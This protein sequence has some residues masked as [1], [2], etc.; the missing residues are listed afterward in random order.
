MRRR[1]AALRA[2]A[3]LCLAAVGLLW[4]PAPEVSAQS[5][6]AEVGWWYRLSGDNP[7]PSGAGAGGAAP[8]QAAPPPTLPP[9]PAPV[10]TI[11]V[12]EDDPPALPAPVPPPATVP[13]GGLYVANDAFGALAIAAVRFPVGQVGS[14]ILTL[15]FADG[16]GGAALPIVA[17]P[18]LEGFQAVAN[19]AWR[20]RP[21]H[22]CD[23]ASVSGALGSDGTLTFQL[24]ERFQQAGQQTLDVVVL[25]LPGDG[26]PFSAPFQA[27]GADALEVLGP[28]PDR[29][30]ASPS[31][32]GT[33]AGPR[34]GST[35]SAVPAQGGSGARSPAV[36]RVP[37]APATPSAGAGGGEAAGGVTPVVQPVAELFDDR[38]WARW[39]AT[40]ILGVLAVAVA[41]ASTGKVPPLAGAGG[42][43]ATKGVGRFA[44][45]REGPPP[46]LT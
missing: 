36:G 17:C 30:A 2:G 6:P 11:P 5:G 18:L 41:A 34:V 8:A 26:T 42:E 21:A 14:S 7:A 13:E 20:D 4:W 24:S 44:R 3:A 33:G 9:S 10:P 38:P 40:S 45:H 19:G 28:P 15:A 22:D 43:S 27:V 29:T 32:S 25:P 31:S 16:A 12:G 23:R 37:A 35:P 46:A 1:T 39:V